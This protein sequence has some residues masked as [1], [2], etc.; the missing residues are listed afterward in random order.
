MDGSSLSAP[1]RSFNHPP[2]ARDGTSDWSSRGSESRPVRRLDADIRVPVKCTAALRMWNCAELV[3]PTRVALIT[4][5]PCPV[6]QNDSLHSHQ[7]RLC[8]PSFDADLQ[9]P[10]SVLLPHL[11]RAATAR[12]ELVQLHLVFERV[13]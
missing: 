10:A 12:E 13:H 1:E 8:Q 4:N 2:R 7:A 9:L 5:P 3:F 11:P 6:Y